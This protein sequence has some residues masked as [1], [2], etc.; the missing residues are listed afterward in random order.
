MADKDT[1][2]SEEQRSLDTLNETVKG[3][4][5]ALEQIP[6]TVKEEVER[7]V[8]AELGDSK[9]HYEEMEERTKK[10]ETNVDALVSGLQELRAPGAVATETREDDYGYGNEP[11]AL[12]DMI[13]EVRAAASGMGTPERLAKMHKGEVERR[14][15]STLTGVGGGYWMRPQFSD[16]LLQIPPDQQW[17]SSLIRNL[18]ATDPPNAEFSFNAFDQ[19]GAKGIFGGVAVYSAKELANLTQTDTPTIMTVNFKPEKTGAYWTVSEE[20]SVNTPQMGSMMQ[21][22]VNGAILSY[23]DDKIQTGTGA[24]E[25]KGFASS[26]A[27]ISV[28]RSAANQVNYIDLLNMVARVMSNGGGR[29]VWLCQRVS[30][31]PQLGSLTDGAGQLIWTRNANDPLPQATLMGIPIFFNE[32]SPSMGTQGDLRLVNLDYYMRKPGMGAMMKSD[33]GILNFLKD[34]ETLKVSYYDDGKPWI[35]APLTLRDGT[36]TVSP[37]VELTDVA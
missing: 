25:F 22:L 4:S 6:E 11:E 12:D 17:L 13:A 31:I 18:P 27:M 9:A 3:M 16:Q 19:S 5:G 28:A 15:L 32:I 37:F 36:N 7:R 21:P 30:M 2:V 23:R 35:T 34:Q 1:N 33:N 14:A 29:F 20:A 10:I 24:G 8:K 26:P